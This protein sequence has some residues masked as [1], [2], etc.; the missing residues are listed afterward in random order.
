MGVSRDTDFEE[1]FADASAL[2]DIE[3]EASTVFHEMRRVYVVTEPTIERLR[4]RYVD[5]RFREIVT[6]YRAVQRTLDKAGNFVGK[7]AAKDAS[8]SGRGPTGY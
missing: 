3:K 7:A 1:F 2:N 6:L 5:A 4:Q 8:A